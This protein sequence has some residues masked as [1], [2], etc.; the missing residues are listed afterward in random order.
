MLGE[1]I[2]SEE[3]ERIG[4]VYK[5]FE[6][7]SFA[8]EAL[9]M[10]MTL[11]QLPTKGLA[12]TKQALNNSLINNYEDQ[13]HDEELLQERAGRTADYNEGVRAFLEKRKP[14]FKGE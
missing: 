8:D 1:K 2:T 7:A 10:A 14:E 6:D 11:A 4:M 9:K 3:A 5:V 12:F 13:L